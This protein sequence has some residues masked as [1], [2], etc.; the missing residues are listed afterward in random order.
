MWCSRMA[1]PDAFL[2]K[3][4]AKKNFWHLQ[5][6]NAT[7]GGKEPEFGPAQ[8][9]NILLRKYFSVDLE[10][11]IPEPDEE[12]DVDATVKLQQTF[13]EQHRASDVPSKGD[14]VDLGNLTDAREGVDP[15]NDEFETRALSELGVSNL[16][17]VFC[18][19]NLS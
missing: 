15:L 14:P 11:I 1:S 8:I 5:K 2:P 6:D 3:E 17:P 19:W 10:L 9:I 13:D 16:I 7:F 4:Y 12:E 18:G